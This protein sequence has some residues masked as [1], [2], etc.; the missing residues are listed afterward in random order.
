MNDDKTLTH[1]EGLHDSVQASGVLDISDLSRKEIKNLAR[2]AA[3]WSGE[4]GTF[5]WQDIATGQADIQ[6][7]FTRHENLFKRTFN[8]QLDRNLRH[9]RKRQLIRDAKNGDV[10]A[11]GKYQAMGTED[12]AKILAPLVTLPAAAG[13]GVLSSILGGAKAIYANPTLRLALDTIGA[14]DGIRNATSD[15]GIKKTIDLAQEGDVWGALKSG[16][17][18]A[19]DIFSIAD[20]GRIGA[21][22]LNRWNRKLDRS[23]KKGYN[24][25]Y[26][27]EGNDL[28]ANIYWKNQNGFSQ[29]GN[30]YSFDKYMKD[31]ALS[32]NFTVEDIYRYVDSLND[33]NPYERAIKQNYR[34]H[35]NYLLTSDTYK[36]ALSPQQ[37]AE[38]LKKMSI[39]DTPYNDEHMKKLVSTYYET[40]ALPRFINNLRDQQYYISDQNLKKITDAFSNPFDHLN[41]VRGYVPQGWGAYAQ[42]TKIYVPDNVHPSTLV[43]EIHHGLRSY[44]G[45]VLDRN[46][47]VIPQSL[48][49]SN[50]SRYLHDTRHYL[51]KEVNLMEPLS[52]S[53]RFRFDKNP[54][55]EIGADV[56]GAG[57]FEKWHQFYNS[58]G[59]YPSVKELDD[60]IDNTLTFEEAM[61]NSYARQIGSKYLE[62]TKLPW[63]KK[64]FYNPRKNL[65]K[66]WKNAMKYLGGVAGTYAVTNQGSNN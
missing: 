31:H 55:S 60:F 45:S 53:D 30:Y 54:M 64:I 50:P 57:R 10:T 36:Q 20:L 7:K 38:E 15:N 12:V 28:N 39:V 35:I 23:Y 27:S 2:K 52:M 6:G 33:S 25:A 61:R 37:I 42:N 63:Y 11:L 3:G 22:R 16:A 5:N 9:K 40:Q 65:L 14:V 29:T 48:V 58:F 21:R 4:N 32:S 47:P 66:S 17:G 43:H 34:N 41:V 18:D 26:K 8:K 19:F 62:S 59:R 56:A 1:N 46:Y 24:K 49:S 51:Q 13:T 44:L